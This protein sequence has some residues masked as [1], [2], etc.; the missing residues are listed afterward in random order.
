MLVPGDL[1]PKGS[2]VCFTHFPG[3]YANVFTIACFIAA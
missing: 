2:S 3:S 1:W